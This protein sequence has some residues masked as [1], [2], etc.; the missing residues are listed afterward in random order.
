MKLSETK[1]KVVVLDETKRLIPTSTPNS[2][3]IRRKTPRKLRP[4]F[5]LVDL[6]VLTSKNFQRSTPSFLG[7]SQSSLQA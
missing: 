3:G 1:R 4:N 7:T 2:P 5:E 6:R